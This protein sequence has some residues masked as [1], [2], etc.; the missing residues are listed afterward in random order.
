MPGRRLPLHRNVI[1]TAPVAAPV[2]NLLD[3]CFGIGRTAQRQHFAENRRQRVHHSG[4]VDG[5]HI[6]AGQIGRAITTDCRA[7]TT[8]MATAFIGHIG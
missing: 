6:S 5:K 1:A 7:N 4:G 3:R 2:V 8:F